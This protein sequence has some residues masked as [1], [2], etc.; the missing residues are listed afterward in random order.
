[1]AKTRSQPVTVKGPSIVT[2]FYPLYSFFPKYLSKSICLIIPG[3]L[4]ITRAQ[5]QHVR[6]LSMSRADLVAV[7][8]TERKNNPQE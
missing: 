1:M 7:D 3:M 5:L 8:E 4:S 2:F 6:F